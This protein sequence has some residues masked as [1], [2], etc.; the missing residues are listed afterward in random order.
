[1]QRDSMPADRGMIFLFRDDVNENFWMENTRIP[2]DI[3][4]LTNAGKIVSI[5]HMEPYKRTGVPS[6]GAYR[7]AIELNAG[8]ADASGVKPGDTVTIPDVVRSTPADP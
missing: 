3:L 8:Q 2:L 7:F 1:M 5:K 6:D 4:Y